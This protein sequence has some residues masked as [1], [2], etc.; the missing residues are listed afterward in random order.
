ML[1]NLLSPSSGVVNVIIQKLGGSSIYFLADSKWFRF[2][3]VVSNIWKEIG[4]SSVVYLAA[5]SGIDPSLY[6]AAIV[7]GAT[8]IQRI[9]RITLPSILPIATTMLILS[10]GKHHERRF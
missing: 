6:E 5:L 2:I 4:W 3:L 1:N 7:D 9:T 8:R 10:H